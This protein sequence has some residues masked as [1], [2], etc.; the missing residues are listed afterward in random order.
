MK[1]LTVFGFVV[2]MLLIGLIATVRNITTSRGPK[3]RRFVR[4][5][6]LTIWGLFVSMILLVYLF[7]PPYRYIIVAFY[8]ILFPLSVYRWSTMHQLI[9]HIDERDT[10]EKNRN[11]DAEA[12]SGEAA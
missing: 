12:S 1:M 2:A 10:Q 3:E 9:R 5:V 8:F 6:C 11:G 4:R 7:G